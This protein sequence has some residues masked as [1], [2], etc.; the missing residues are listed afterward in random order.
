M[1]AHFFCKNYTFFLRVINKV[2]EIGVNNSK[3][4]H[5]NSSI[6]KS[7]SKRSCKEKFDN[8]L[9]KKVYKSSERD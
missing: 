3:W 6:V 9:I 5:T 4:K 8:A 7:K 1:Y 2:P